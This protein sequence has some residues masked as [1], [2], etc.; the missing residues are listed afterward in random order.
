[1]TTA[2]IK[3]RNGVPTMCVDGQPFTGWS[4]QRAVER[5]PGYDRYDWGD[6]AR[7]YRQAAQAGAGLFLFNSNCAGDFY[8]RLWGDVWQ[9]DGTFDFSHLDQFMEIFQRDCP[10]VWL[11]P[12]INMFLPTWWDDQHPDELL[13]F[14][15]EIGRAHV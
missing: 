3:N 1:M 14:A 9:A 15:D 6:L 13:R 10:G 8:E 5:Y 4:Y 7:D 2:T 11:L 12:Q